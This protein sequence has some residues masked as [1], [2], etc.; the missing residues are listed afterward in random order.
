MSIYENAVY[1]CSHCGKTFGS[2]QDK[3]NHDCRK[4]VKNVSNPRAYHGSYRRRL[5][6]GS[7]GNSGTA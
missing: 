2:I 5:Q 7:N 3:Q 1:L 6:R 4:E